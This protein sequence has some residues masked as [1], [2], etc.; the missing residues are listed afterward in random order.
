MKIVKR[1]KNRRLYDTE[2]KKYITHTELTL[3]VRSK[4]PF[5]VI[6]NATGKDI[7]LPVLGQLFVGQLRDSE[8]IKNSKEIL[9]EAINL[10][11]KKSMSI[12]KNTFLAGVGIFNLTKKKAEELIDSLIKAGEISKSDRKQAILELLDKAEESTV[13]MKDKVV[14]ETAGI[15]KEITKMADKVKKAAEKFPQKRIMAELEK[16]NKKVD[17][18]A[19]KVNEQG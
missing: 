17:D 15:Q 3:I 13:K 7:T 6:D 12:L 11:G 5:C 18:L 19:K 2:E 4:A 10:G 14:K 9:I 16:L 1:Y 8:D